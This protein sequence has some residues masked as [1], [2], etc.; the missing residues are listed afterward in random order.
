MKTGCMICF[1]FSSAATFVHFQRPGVNTSANSF[2]SLKIKFSVANEH[3]STFLQNE[4][5]GKSHKLNSCIQSEP[6]RFFEHV[7]F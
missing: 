6:N 2:F 1:N 7:H 3:D 5:I 4:D